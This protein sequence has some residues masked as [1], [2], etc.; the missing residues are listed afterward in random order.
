MND[1]SYIHDATLNLV[2]RKIGRSDKVDP[3]KY[4]R[5]GEGGKKE[6]FKGQYR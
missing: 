2:T 4:R 5:R 1:N 3:K 6:R